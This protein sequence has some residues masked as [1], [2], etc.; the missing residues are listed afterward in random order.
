MHATRTSSKPRAVALF[1][2]LGALSFGPAVGSFAGASTET[3]LR[4][5]THD[6]WA[7]SE[8]LLAR[9]EGENGV[10][11]EILT[12]G[13]AGSAVNTAILAKG[14]PIADVLYGIDN[15]FLSRALDADIFLPYAPQALAQVPDEY[16]IDPQRRVTPIN[17][18]DVCLNYDIAGLQE[19][20]LRPPSSL[21]Q[22]VDQ[23]YRSLLVVPSPVT[24]S[25]GL[26]FL[27]A[28]IGHFGEA[29]YLDFWRRLR[30][31]NVMVTG[32]WESAYFGEFSGA[33]EGSRP[34]VVSYG[35]SPPFEVLFAE[36]AIAA[37][38]TAAIVAAN[39]CFR[40]IEFAGVLVGTQNRDLA[41]RWMDFLLSRE[42]QE[43]L[44]LNMFVFPVRSDAEL[45]ETFRH[46]LAVP[47]DPVE[48][49]PARIASERE[50]WIREWRHVMAR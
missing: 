33:S 32:D 31:N 25:P 37:P 15:T 26:A 6:S 10:E 24:S 36:Q 14:N 3:V 43:D 4:V 5:M 45:N 34:L 41:E 2:A 23:R 44:P 38:S 7:L 12:S 46:F 22:L 50:R 19:M 42:V 20:Q 11:V 21:D 40:Q 16:Q 39:T 47:D 48:V 35:S 29:G 27:L 8:Q 28:T 1:A 18:G 17:Y 30:A 49:D 13:D 9:F